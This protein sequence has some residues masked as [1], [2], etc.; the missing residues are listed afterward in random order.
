MN[1]LI[2]FCEHS[3]DE[4]V[5]GIVIPGAFYEIGKKTLLD[6]G[7]EFQSTY[8]NL[9][10]FYSKEFDT[11]MLNKFSNFSTLDYNDFKFFAC[12]KQNFSDY[13]DIINEDDF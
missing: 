1:K 7:F 8:K 13:L 12:K 5:L 10:L 6:M 2:G 4:D 9:D 3:E 11:G